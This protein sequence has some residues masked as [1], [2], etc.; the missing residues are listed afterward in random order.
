MFCI[1]LSIINIFSLLV[2][3]RE[4]ERE[5][6]GERNK[7]ENREEKDRIDKKKSV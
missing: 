2:R 5:E 1:T 3:E 6:R 4:R 7:R